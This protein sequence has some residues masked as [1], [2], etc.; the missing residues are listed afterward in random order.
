MSVLSS[1][2]GNDYGGGRETVFFFFRIVFLG[3]ASQVSFH[4]LLSAWQA[5]ALH[6][7]KFSGSFPLSAPKGS[8]EKLLGPQ[9][10]QPTL[11]FIG[12]DKNVYEGEEEEEGE[13]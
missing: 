5:A 13:S 9:S 6:K 1:S 11:S 10:P 8:E 12:R 4:T 7:S 2:S 3:K